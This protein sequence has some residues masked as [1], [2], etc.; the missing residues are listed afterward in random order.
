MSFDK[1]AATT[2]HKAET[3]TF[4][5]E[6]RQNILSSAECAGLTWNSNQ[7]EHRVNHARKLER[8]S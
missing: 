3:Y 7:V 5:D 2:E 4:T 6:D 1:I 8:R